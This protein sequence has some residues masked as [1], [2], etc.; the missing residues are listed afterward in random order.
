MKFSLIAI[1]FIFAV[2]LF[3]ADRWGAFSDPFPI[4]DVAPYGDNGIMLATD[5]GLRFRTLEGDRVFLSQDGLETSAFYSV[6][7]ST[8]GTFA[9]SEFGIVVAINGDGNTWRVLNRSYVKNN[10]RAVPRGA[11]LGK[12][13]LVIAFEDR[14]AFFDILKSTSLLTVDRIGNYS[15]QMNALKQLAV[16]GDTLYVKTERTS[17]SRVMDWDGLAS[18]IHLGDA[19]SWNL[20]S[21]ENTVSEFAPWDST[22]VVAGDEVLTES[23]LFDNNGCR[24]R[25]TLRS[26]D[27]YFLV[28]PYT[29][30]FLHDQGTPRIV[31]LPYERYTLGEAYE[32]QA[33]PMGG[34]LAA[35]VD[36]KIGYAKPTGWREPEYGERLFRL[37]C[38]DEGAVGPSGRVRIL[39]Y[40]GLCLPDLFPLGNGAGVL[41]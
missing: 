27:G 24:V 7:S 26:K 31:D 5:G 39:S 22:K 25:W 13:I 6:V 4:H 1:V 3:A 35:S 12:N 2:Q 21:A 9:V 16:H 38:Q 33:M 40:L 10:V 41:L 29:I 17:Y 8:L 34:V 23:F 15:L 11:V 14:L 36:G 20:L 30:L 19:S 37:F 18:D 32:L 28:G